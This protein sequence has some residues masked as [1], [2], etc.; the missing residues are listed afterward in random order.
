M[1]RSLSVLCWLEERRK[2]L[3]SRKSK[4][5]PEQLCIGIRDGRVQPDALAATAERLVRQ[6][7]GPLFQSRHDEGIMYVL[8]DRVGSLRK[9][10]VSDPDVPP[11]A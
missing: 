2:L 5:L 7:L 1:S 8:C 3:A 6:L 11:G 9:L 4:Y 10:A